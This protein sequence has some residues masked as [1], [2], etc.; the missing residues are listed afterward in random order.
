MAT[1]SASLRVP[2]RR[3]FYRRLAA[4]APSPF[5]RFGPLDRRFKYRDAHY[6]LKNRERF[7]R[8]LSA[9]ARHCPRPA[10]RRPRETAFLPR[11]SPAGLSSR[12]GGSVT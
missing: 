3:A 5:E 6:V 12:R 2:G 9:V 7:W 4:Y 11:A 10:C 8:A 1:G